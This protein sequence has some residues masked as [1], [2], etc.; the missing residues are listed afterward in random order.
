MAVILVAPSDMLP[1]RTAAIVA[2]GTAI[3]IANEMDITTSCN[4]AGSAAPMSWIRGER[5]YS[6]SGVTVSE[7]CQVVQI[8]DDHWVVQPKNISYL[9]DLFSSGAFPRQRLVPD[10]QESA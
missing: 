6:T 2:A 8:L 3:T 4:V 10:P 1:R 5:W 7:A 9:L